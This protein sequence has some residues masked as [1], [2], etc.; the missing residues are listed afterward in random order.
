VIAND[1]AMY[2]TTAIPSSENSWIKD[3]EKTERFSRGRYK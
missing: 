3:G 2:M 1:S